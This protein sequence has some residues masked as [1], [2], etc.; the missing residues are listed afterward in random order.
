MPRIRST[1]KV[2][3]SINTP[4]SLLVGSRSSNLAVKQ[5]ISTLNRIQQ[6]FPRLDFTI[7]KMSSPGD[8]DLATDLRLASSNFF[9]HD[10]DLA[11]QEEEIDCAIHS[12][13]DLPSPMPEGLDYFLVPWQEDNRDC[14][15]ISEKF[16]NAPHG[17]P[18]VGISSDR[19][20][21]YAKKR[22][23][24]CECKMLRGTIEHRLEQLDNGSFDILIMAAAALKRLDL[25]ER[26]NEW[27]STDDLN[28][29]STQG[30][31][32]ITFNKKCPVMNEMARF[33]RKT[34][35]DGSC[36]RSARILLTDGESF[37][38]IAAEKIAL[39]RGGSCLYPQM[40][41]IPE[42][43][44]F[45]YSVVD[46]DRIILTSAASIEFFAQRI[47]E[48]GI[49]HDQL[50]PLDVCGPGSDEMMQQYDLVAAHCTPD[51]Y[52]AN[53]IIK[54]IA[55][56]IHTGQKIL[57][58]RSDRTSFKISY[59]L[60]EMGAIVTDRILYKNEAVENTR[61]PYFD[62][63]FFFTKAAVELF[64]EQWGSET[65]KNRDIVVL[66]KSTFD[67]LCQLMP[68]CHALQAIEPN[69]DSMIATL[70]EVYSFREQLLL[71]S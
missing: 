36:L 18:V 46:Y 14:L 5:T 48:L 59:A 40:H 29:P 30:Q 53:G 58:L 63:V 27:I 39:A 70:V 23:P 35:R 1:K 12:A 65:L 7:C 13:K 20:E 64:I 32:A 60:K 52:G 54:H 62:A 11:V 47:N 55:H 9:T 42:N 57:R 4:I 44:V 71:L 50:P 38:K 16:K 51:R 41:Q 37:N 6:L 10:L 67:A 24:S 66:D 15:V 68:D 31:L 34:L 25:S 56:E 22:F 26:I 17:N 19:R 33:F 28:V 2:W 61:L 3:F 8:K 21:A 43:D 69:V 45:D 49:K